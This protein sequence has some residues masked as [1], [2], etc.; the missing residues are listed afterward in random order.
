MHS[1]TTFS[2]EV[3]QSCGCVSRRRQ[4]G[5][6]VLTCF[7]FAGVGRLL[8]KTADSMMLYDI[9]SLK[10]VAELPVQGRYPVKQVVWNK[11]NKFV[12]M[13]SKAGIII[14]SSQ[15]EE[16]CTIT[17]TSKIK[18][19]AWDP[20]GVF[21]FTTATHIKVIFFSLLDQISI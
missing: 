14:A 3:T 11:D 19:G 7:L 18:S 12:A 10:V 20:C 2:K 16:K 15:L 9:Q 13:I 6:R 21:V 5:F 8:L 4:L 1:S 17:E